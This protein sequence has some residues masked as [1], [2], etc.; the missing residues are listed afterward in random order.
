MISEEQIQFY[1][2]QLKNGM[3]DGELKEQLKRE[4]LTKEEVDAVFKPHHYDM[5]AW[6]LVF[7]VLITLF[8]FYVYLQTGGILILI[9]GSLLFVAYYYEL[10]R[11]ERLKKQE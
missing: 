9:L 2:K 10:K 6:Y 7:G 5:R 11:L 1:R 3:P 4:G 8:G